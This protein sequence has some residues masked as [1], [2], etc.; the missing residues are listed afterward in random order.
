MLRCSIPSWNRLLVQAAGC[1][2]L[3]IAAMGSSAAKDHA[4]LLDGPFKTGSEVTQ[5]C[6]E[7]HKDEAHD[8]MKT[9]HWTWSSRQ[10]A[11]G[12]KNEVNL[13]KANAVNN[14]CIALPGNEPRCTS[15]HAGY[16]WKDQNFDFKNAAN[17]D[18]LVCHDTTGSYKKLPAG[19]GHPAY[20]DTEFPPKSGKMWKAV[21]LLKVA[22]SVGNTSRAT[23]GS[24]H[25]Y[26]GGGDH[27]K[28]GDLDSS[29]AAPARDLDVHMAVDGANMTCT[30]CHRTENHVIA[31]KALSVSTTG[32]NR[33]LA[34]TDCHAGRPHKTNRELDRHTTNVACQTCHVPAFA[35]QLPTKMWWDWS[36]A[37]QDRPPA[38]DALGMPTYDRQKGDFRWGKNVVPAYRWFDGSVDR[39]LIGERINPNQVVALN[40]PRGARGSAHAKITPFKQMTGK[41][42]Y[43]SGASVMAMP[44]LFGKGGYWDT[45]DW[46]TA[47]TSGMKAANVPYS[48]QF[49]W[50]QTEMYWKVNHM[51]S[52]KK[53]ALG[54]N[55]CHGANG[56]MDWKALGYPADPRKP[57]R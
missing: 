14:F 10:R 25:F 9:V 38:K 29:M 42:P 1:V 7:C 51:V 2:F 12:A 33:T 30:D 31:G 50:V 28:H 15:C 11:E 43:D 16:G 54:C 5:A 37:G 56:R 46:S 55:D 45:Y 35:R 3:A 39:V 32:S 53:K 20:Q 24:C 19:A 41:Q 13:G 6:L 21:D 40:Q 26:G 22:R 52:P 36:T 4:K 57:A 49:G 27:I 34:C 47:I 48:G 23:C 8:F 17:I 18:C 44:H